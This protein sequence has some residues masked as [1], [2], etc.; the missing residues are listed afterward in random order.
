MTGA[1]VTDL[2]K[3]IGGCAGG[4]L[5]VAL[6]VQES[7]ESNTKTGFQLIEVKNETPDKV[8]VLVVYESRIESLT[9]KRNL[10][11]VVSDV[12]VA[13]TARKFIVY[14]ETSQEWF[15]QRAHVTLQGELMSSFFN[16]VQGW[17]E[18]RLFFSSSANAAESA[19]V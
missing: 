14:T 11:V 13:H 4:E 6:K 12:F 2:F 15:S 5:R 10:L 9:T 3:S 17:E 16:R 18:Q 7:M 8:Y 19:R 1:G